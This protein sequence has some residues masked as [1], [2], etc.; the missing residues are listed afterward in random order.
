VDKAKGTY[1]PLRINTLLSSVVHDFSKDNGLSASDLF[2]LAERYHA[3]SGSDLQ[4]YTLPTVG[5][6]SDAAGDV[7]VVQPDEASQTIT[8]F[9][10][11]PFGTITTPPIDAYGNELTLTVPTTVPTVPTTAVPATTAPSTQKAP[12][13]TT[14]PPAS[15]IPYYDPRPC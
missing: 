11:G 1:N 7:E 4:S 14:A 10:G 6:Q 15:N 2:S 12:T 3:F 8:Q 13:T 5:A 9:L